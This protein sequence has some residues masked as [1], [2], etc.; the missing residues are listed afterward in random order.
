[1]D[2]RN[3][4]STIPHVVS[5]SPELQ[6]ETVMV[7][8]GKRRSGKLLGVFPSYFSIQKMDLHAGRLFTAEQAEKGEQ[9]CVIGYGLASKFF[10]GEDPIGKSLKCGPLWFTVVG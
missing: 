1:D 6:Y 8:D 4:E 3:I 5:A 2:L 7:R 10:P 9:V